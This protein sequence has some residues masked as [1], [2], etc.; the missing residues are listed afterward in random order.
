MLDT[1]ILLCFIAAFTWT[2]TELL[3]YHLHMF[4]LNSYKPKEHKIWLKA[5]DN[6]RKLILLLLQFALAMSAYLLFNMAG[7]CIG[8]IFLCFMAIMNRPVKAKK[9]LVYTNRVKR[10]LI[11]SYVIYTLFL[12]IGSVLN[13]HIYATALIFFIVAVLIPVWVLIANRINQPI[14][15]SIN[16][17]FIN[18]AQSIIDSMPNLTVIGVT[19][20]YGKT[21]VKFYLQKLLS[22]KYNVLVT[23]ENFNTTLGVVRTIR[24][25]LRATHEIFVCEMGAKNIGDIKEICDLVHPVH[26]VITSI[27]P[28]H[29]ESFLSIDNVIKTKFELADAIGKKGTLFLNYDNE[30]IVNHKTDN[31]VITYG[32]HNEASTYRPYDVS[33]S[34]KGS[35]FKLKDTQNKEWEFSTRLIGAHNVV[36][37]AGAIAVAHTLGVPMEALVVQV[38]RLEGVP[39][40]LQLIKGNHALI[41][42]D[43]YNSNPSGAKAALDTLNTFEG[44]KIVVTPGMVELGSQQY[45]CNK[46]FGAQIAA[47]CDYAVLV[48][49]KQTKPIQD[50]LLEADYPAAKT[51]VA[52]DLKDAL[53]YV[54]K[55]NTNSV[56]KVVLLE[57]DLPDNY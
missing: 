29:L 3:L 17:G 9:P 41:I 31:N 20:S 46:I 2:F 42:D 49:S 14:E 15:A 7:K 50:G 48:G 5:P 16:R 38:R 40:R 21:S 37:I 44:I 35:A 27:G 25:H 32:I 57:N 47:V 56:Q 30:S 53:A 6:S 10:M 1:I 23:P 22:A 26:G 54:E 45:E 8:I 36:N 18:E 34:S 43:A 4:Q 28:Q 51:Y 52:E 11:T 24:E 39:H 33:V 19:G 12:I 55:L 13:R